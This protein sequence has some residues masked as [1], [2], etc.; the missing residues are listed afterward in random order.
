MLLCHRNSLLNIE[1]SFLKTP[2]HEIETIVITRLSIKSG[3]IF[4]YRPFD[5]GINPWSEGFFLCLKP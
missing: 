5:M 1:H 4:F 2:Y 3:G